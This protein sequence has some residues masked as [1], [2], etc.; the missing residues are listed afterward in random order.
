MEAVGTI[1]AR[2]QAAIIGYGMGMTQ[3]VN[4]V[5]NVQMVVNLLLMRGN[6]GKPGAGVMP[7]RGHSNVQGQRTVG[8]TE[9][10]DLVPNDKLKELYGFDPPKDKGLNCTQ[11]AEAVIKGDVRAV[12]QLGGNLVRSL[13]DHDRLLPAWRKL[14]LTVQI[15]TKLNKSCLVHG[16]VSYILPCLGR[17]E[18]DQQNGSPQA[19]SVEDSTACIYGSRGYAKPA[20]TELRSEPWIVGALAKAVLPQNSEVNWDGWVSDY[21]QIRDA[22]ELTYPEMFKDFNK[23]MWLPGG[24]HRPLPACNRE[25]K[26]KTGKANFISPK[27]LTADIKTD[28]ERSDIFQLSTFRSQGQ[29]NTTVYSYRDRFRGVHGTRMAL[30]M[31]E[32]DIVRLGLREGEIVSLRTAVGDDAVR[33][34]DGFIVHTYNIPEGCLGGYYPECNPLI[35]LWHHAVGSFVPASKGVPV[36]VERTGVAK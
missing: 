33:R 6:I 1:Y 16:E 8:I 26:T 34:V 3:H 5:E 13:P 27:T 35:P 18:I 36:V 22:I 31:N 24:F 17:I 30:F 2:A 9:K 32:N 7:I 14:R 20:S 10:P 28:P 23:R 19:V 25:W 12:V 4:G 21:S 15:E 11:A 29:F